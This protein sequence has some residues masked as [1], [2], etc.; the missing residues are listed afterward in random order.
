VAGKGIWFEKTFNF[1]APHSKVTISFDFF[2]LD[3]WDNEYFVVKAN[4][5]DVIRE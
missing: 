1:P 4:G 3:S 5:N 2:G